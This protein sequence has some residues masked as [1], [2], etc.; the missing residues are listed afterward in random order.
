[1]DGSRVIG[2]KNSFRKVHKV[3]LVLLP[4]VVIYKLKV[5][6]FK[7]FE[8]NIV[9]NAVRRRKVD[10]LSLLLLTFANLL[11]NVCHTI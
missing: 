8:T 7:D 1:M 10:S 3:F 2:L 9:V 6:V 4:Q 5:S 11:A